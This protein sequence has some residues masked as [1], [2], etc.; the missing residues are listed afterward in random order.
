MAKRPIEPTVSLVVA[1]HNERDN[2]EAKLENCLDLDYPEEKLQV[3]VSL[4]A[5]TDGTDLVAQSYA[6]SRVEVVGSAVRGGKA[7][8]INRGV[9]IARGSIV[10][11][12]DAKQRLERKAIREL[13]ANFADESVGAVSGELVL[14]DAGGREARDSVG[15]YWRYEKKIRAMESDIHSVPGATGAIYAIRRDLFEPLAPGTILDDVAI[16][17]RIVLGGHRAVFD[18]A[19]RA[20]DAV[21]GSP[22]D[23]YIRKRRT[24][25]GN[26]QLFAEMPELLIPWRNPIFIQVI[27]HKAGRLIVPYCLGVLFL[28]NLFLLDGWY[29]VSMALQVVWYVMAGAGWWMSHRREPASTALRAVQE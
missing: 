29:R 22:N 23:E 7:E 26:Y 19:A 8:A 18:P 12:V 24:L 17:M 3:I 21:T 25:A 16:P 15:A 9:R 13:A 20:Y 1:M 10:M 28:A 2:V 5:P 4:D 11:F 6:S 14:L 27:S